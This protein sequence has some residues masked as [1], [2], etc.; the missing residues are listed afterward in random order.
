MRIIIVVIFFLTALSSYSQSITKIKEIDSLVTHTN[1]SDFKI[2]YDSISQDM[3]QLGLWTKTYLT[4]IL[5]GDELK[6]YVSRG[7]ATRLENGVMTKTIT[8]TLFYFAKGKL[9]KVEEFMIAEEKI[10]TLHWYFSEDKPLYYTLRS[11]KAEE[12]AD[13]LLGMADSMLKRVQ[14]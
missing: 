2:Q 6:K 13:L 3:P 12:R 9:I 5:D 7:N 11:D 1:N 8:S 4:V 14:K 10:Q